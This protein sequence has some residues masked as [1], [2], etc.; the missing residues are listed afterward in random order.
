MLKWLLNLWTRNHNKR[1]SCTP[2]VVNIS[3]SKA[4]WIENTSYK[5]TKYTHKVENGFN[6]IYCY[7][8]KVPSTKQA[9]SLLVPRIPDLTYPQI[10][11]FIEGPF[12]KL[13]SNP[14]IGLSW[15]PKGPKAVGNPVDLNNV[16]DQWRRSDSVPNPNVPAIDLPVNASFVSTRREYQQCVYL[17][18]ESGH[19]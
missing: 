15:Q 16:L 18:F 9:P 6:D 8:F 5:Y 7:W 4:Q 11:F 1:L 14:S 13:A 19:R 10:L 2:V 12:I 17:P 3:S